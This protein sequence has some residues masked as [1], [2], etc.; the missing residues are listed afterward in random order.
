MP[1]KSLKCDNSRTC[2]LFLYCKD[3]PLL[4]DFFVKMNVPIL[5]FS[6]R[7]NY[8]TVET[9]KLQHGFILLVGER[10]RIK[11]RKFSESRRTNGMLYEWQW[12]PFLSNMKRQPGWDTW[13]THCWKKN[14]WILNTFDLLVCGGEN[15]G[16]TAWAG[17]VSQISPA[18]LFPPFTYR[19]FLIEVSAKEMSV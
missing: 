10:P 11:F 3:S 7:R 9:E 6:E 8:P 14:A 16:L 2:G 4:P 18:C 1:S 15:V 13:T 17:E 5:S 12:F 19:R